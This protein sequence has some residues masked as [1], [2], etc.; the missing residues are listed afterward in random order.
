MRYFERVR[1]PLGRKGCLGAAMTAIAL[2]HGAPALAQE[3]NA[4]SSEAAAG[5]QIIVTGSRIARDGFE[6]PTPVVVLTQEDIQ[7]TSPSNNVADFVNQLPQ[8]AG[9]TRP[10]TDTAGVF[11]TRGGRRSHCMLA[12][13]LIERRRR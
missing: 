11:S 1:R 7:N 6:A 4:D 8:L 5:D 10:A 13:R 12:A 3:A 2:V 9:S